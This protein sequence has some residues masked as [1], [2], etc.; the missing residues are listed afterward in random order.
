ME[1]PPFNFYS[2]YYIDN[3]VAVNVTLFLKIITEDIA[4]SPVVN[5][6]VTLLTAHATKG[7]EYIA[8]IVLRTD[9]FK[10]KT[11]KELEEERRLLYVT[12]T[13]SKEKGFI[14]DLGIQNGVSEI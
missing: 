7:S 4:N 3:L 5:N 2:L 12:L 11:D 10:A 9:R 8:V 1:P 6:G 13:S 14:K